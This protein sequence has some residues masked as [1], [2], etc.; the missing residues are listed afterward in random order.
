MHHIMDDIVQGR[1]SLGIEFGSTRI[2]AI[3]IDSHQQTIVSGSYDWENQLVDGVWTYSLD[4]VWT[5][6]QSAYRQL[7]E[8]VQ[9]KYGIHLTQIGQIGISAMMHGYMAFDEKDQLL[10]PFRTW[11]N[12]ITGQ[13]AEELSQLFDFNIP[14]RWSI[15]HLYQAVLNKEEHVPNISFLTTLAGYIHWQLTGQKV[16]GVGDASG[17][18]P[19][20][21]DTGYYKENF[22]ASFDSLIK[23]YDFSWNLR[24]ILPA[25]L[26][27]GSLAGVLTPE[28]ANR[29]DPTGQL[30]SGARLCPPEGDAG[31]GMVATNSVSQRTGNVSAGTSI[32]AM[33]VLERALQHRHS[34]IDIVTTPVG[35]TVAMVHANNCSSDINAWVKL[36]Q[37]FSVLSGQSISSSDIYPLLFN[38]ALSGEKDCGGLLSYGYYS[39]ESITNINEGRPLLVRTPESR[40]SVPNLMRSH[41]LSAFSTLAIGMEILVDEEH[42]QIDSILGHGGIFKTPQVA[43]SLLAAAIQIPVSVMDTAGEGGA[44]GIALLAD[45]LN[46]ATEQPLSSYLE[47]IVF[48]DAPVE[49]IEPNS[50]DSEG[51]KVFLANYKKGL[52]IEKV[53]VERV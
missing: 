39:G 5:G 52:A 23:E 32:F 28:G 38:A 29:L 20:D 1:T 14:E 4:A 47:E 16:L 22:L 13:A 40:F 50:E 36:F 7:V 35:D 26:P 44:W 21:S 12:T 30:K 42:I 43:Q 31:T 3:L 10:V 6:L 17:M 41:I 18:F 25:V 34:E 19:I 27:A 45:Y 49:T 24:S 15:A 51:F 46:Y 37:E 11:R 9:S 2:K 48:V 8:E 33:I 53:A